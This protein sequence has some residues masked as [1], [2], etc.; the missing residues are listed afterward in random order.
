M[1][2]QLKKLCPK[3]S[4]IVS[5]IIPRKGEER[6]HQVNEDIAAVNAMLR[7]TCEQS[8]DV[9]FCDNSDFVFDD[10]K[11]VRNQLYED[12]IHLNPVG[13]KELCKSIFKKVKEVYYENTLCKVCA[14][15]V[16]ASPQRVAEQSLR[17]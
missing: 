12:Y 6:F 13:R 14:K 8:N 5:S 3:S 10:E 1:V 9:H 11:Q 4:I 15:I 16:C 2:I 7:D 17:N